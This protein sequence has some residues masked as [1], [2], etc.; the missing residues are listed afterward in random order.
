MSQLDQF[1]TSA[2]IEASAVMGLASFTIS[3]QNGT[4][5]GVLNEFESAK[6]ID[7][8]GIMASY[9]ATLVCSLSQFSAVTGSLERTID[10]RTIT[11]SG[12]TFKAARCAVDGVAITIGLVNPTKR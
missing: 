8:G 1:S 11:I 5:T 10:G 9:G 7:I 4:F 6:E 12:R 3:G 2:F